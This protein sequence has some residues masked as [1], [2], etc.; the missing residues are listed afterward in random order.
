MTDEVIEDTLQDETQGVVEETTGSATEETKPEV[1]EPTAEEVETAKEQKRQEAFNKQYGK[2]K[3]AERERD[4]LQAKLDESQQSTQPPPEV[5][6]FPNEYDFD[7]TELFEQAKAQYTQNIVAN[8]N[9]NAQIQAQQNQA[10]A[11]QQAELNKQAVTDNETAS[12]VISKAK[13][14]GIEEVEVQQNA[15]NLIDYGM[16]VEAFRMIA[17]DEESPL[18]MKHL[19]A[20]SQEVARLNAMNPYEAGAY[21]AQVLKPEAIKLKPTSTKTPDPAKDVQGGGADKDA[22]KYPHIKGAVFE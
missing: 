8:A 13:S 7:T 9:Y 15:Q 10:Q 12:K 21:I 18:I 22:G 11:N 2:T 14:Y 16:N 3:Q 5:G 4:A 17:Q 6:G 20:N 1:K 19:S